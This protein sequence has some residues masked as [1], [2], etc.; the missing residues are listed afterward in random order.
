VAVIRFSVQ[1]K[2][3]IENCFDLARDI[4]LHT[5]SMA[6]TRERAIAGVTSGLIG[7]GQEVTWEA[8]HF[9]IRQRL[10]SRITIFERPNRFRDSMVKGA[11]KRF[12]HDHLFSEVGGI[13]TMTDQFDYEAPCALLG[14]IAERAFLTRYMERLLRNRAEVIRVTAES[15]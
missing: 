10:T 12:D 1:I 4:D 9:G 14:K 11:F 8:R 15:R 6:P 5:R 3:P 7:P 13:T 2:A